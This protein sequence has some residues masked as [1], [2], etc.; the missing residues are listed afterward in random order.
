MSSTTPFI[1]HLER[2]FDVR[3]VIA[4]GQSLRGNWKGTAGTA[5]TVVM[6]SAVAIVGFASFGSDVLASWKAPENAEQALAASQGLLTFEAPASTLAFFQA[7]EKDELNGKDLVDVAALLV[8]DWKNTSLTLAQFNQIEQL[9]LFFESY[10][11][12]GLIENG[13]DMENV[14]L[15]VAFEIEFNRL[16]SLLAPPASPSS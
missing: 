1:I 6:L 5:L 3:Y 10:V 2:R 14:M 15:Y 4:I 9:L 13:M 12:Q 8:G 16:F 11:N 7:K